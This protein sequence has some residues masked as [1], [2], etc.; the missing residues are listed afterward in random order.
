MTDSQEGY[1]LVMIF[2]TFPTRKCFPSR[3]S[4]PYRKSVLCWWHFARLTWWTNSFFF[5]CE[6]NTVVHYEPLFIVM[7]A[8]NQIPCTCM[9][10]SFNIAGLLALT[11]CWDVYTLCSTCFCS[12]SVK[13]AGE[14][15]EG[16]PNGAHQ[17]AHLANPSGSDFLPHPQLPSQGCE[18]WEHFDHQGRYGEAVWQIKFWSEYEYICIFD[19]DQTQML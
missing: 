16:G 12:D 7:V 18:A 19:L 17:E 13:W 3:K 2:H 5:S 6:Y 8:G 1:P 10:K 11:A 14:V 4:F 15:P 9:W